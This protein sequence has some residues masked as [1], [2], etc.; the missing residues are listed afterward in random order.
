[1]QLICL[2][3]IKITLEAN[4][5]GCQG[6]HEYCI[7]HHQTRQPARFFALSV[8]LEELPKQDRNA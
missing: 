1:M 2:T 6:Q 3:S 8:P 7:G 4:L 5:A